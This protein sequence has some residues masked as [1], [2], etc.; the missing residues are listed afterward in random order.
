MERR[1]GGIGRGYEPRAPYAAHPE[2]SRGRLIAEPESPTRS[3]FQRDRDRII[4]ANAFRR[5][6]HKTQV[7]IAEEGDHYRTRL[8]HTLEVSQIARALARALRL[9][10]ELAEAIALAHDFGHTPFGHTGEDALNAV[11]QP[12]GGFDHNAQTLRIVT[13]LEHRYAGFDGLN[14]TW[15]S[16]EG[17]VKHNGPVLGPHSDGRPAAPYILEFN[18]QFD[19]HLAEFAGAEAQCAAIAD[20]IAYNAH[21]IDDGLRAGLINFDQL[22]RLELTGPLLAELHHSYP[23]LDAPRRAYELVRRQITGMVEDVIAEASARL[24]VLRPQSIADIYRA[25]KPIVV[26]SPL[27]AGQEKQLKSFLYNNL[28]HHARLAASR[29]EAEDILKDLFGYYMENAAA[30]PA[31]WQRRVEQAGARGG[32]AAYAR[33]IADFIA[34]MTD[35]YALERCRSL[36]GRKSGL[37][38]AGHGPV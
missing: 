16:L 19:L 38:A 6:M 1:C 22:S 25:D 4:H 32:D 36:F 13:L 23:R 37:A 18:R 15:E 24:A 14:L 26:F 7:F 27:M 12:Y 34:G 10:E 11:M 2:L 28:Y 9:D 33:I 30:L 31:E 20:D 17:L 29:A 35:N 21:D 8:T 3:C 5:L